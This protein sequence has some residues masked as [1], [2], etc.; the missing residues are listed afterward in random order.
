M[1]ATNAA[2]VCIDLVESPD[3]GGWYARE[4]DLS[5]SPGRTRTSRKIYRD[6]AALVSALQSGEHHWGR[7]S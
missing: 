3:D 4:Y 2:L 6:R 7:W 5:V 1:T